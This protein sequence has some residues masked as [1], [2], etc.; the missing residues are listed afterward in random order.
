MALPSFTTSGAATSYLSINGGL[1]KVVGFNQ[2]SNGDYADF[3]PDG[4]DPANYSK[5]FQQHRSG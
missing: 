1:T 5:C 4:R 2:D 3:A